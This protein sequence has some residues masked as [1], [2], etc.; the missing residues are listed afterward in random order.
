[1]KNVLLLVVLSASYF[2]FSQAY[3]GK[4]DQKLNIGADFQENATGIQF[5]YDYG[6]GQNLSVGLA[7]NYA[8]GLSGSVDGANFDQRSALRLRLNANLGNVINISDNFDVYPGLS[9]STKNF[10]GHVGARYFFT[11]GF[12]VFTE[13]AF[14][15][16][17]YKT[18]DLNPAEE[19]YNQFNFSI[20]ASFNL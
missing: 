4:G 5:S 14:P 15:F 17:K 1:M 10:G 13:A 8:M 20:G 2:G 18:E 19:L 9:F 3:S 16:S 7:A 12:G 6:I 11:D